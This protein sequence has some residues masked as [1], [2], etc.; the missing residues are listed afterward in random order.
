MS[1]K[2]FNNR[3]FTLIEVV[4]SIIIAAIMGGIVLSFVR[5]ANLYSVNSMNALR[6]NLQIVQVMERINSEYR[7]QIESNDFDFDSFLENVED[8][9]TQQVQVDAKNI[10]IVSNTESDGDSDRI[11]KVKVI[12]KD[13]GASVVNLFT[14]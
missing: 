12:S 7:R 14:S 2:G 4:A 3:G 13:T 1:I 9:S 10:S 8:N 6:G 11:M 5:S